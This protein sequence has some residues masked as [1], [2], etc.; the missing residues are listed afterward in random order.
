MTPGTDLYGMF[1]RLWT[2]AV[3]TEKYSKKEWQEFEQ[4]I[5]KTQET[6]NETVRRN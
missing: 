5:K 6:Q 3:G 1:H 2:K 4:L